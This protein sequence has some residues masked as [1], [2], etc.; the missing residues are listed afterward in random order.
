MSANRPKTDGSKRKAPKTAFR[1]GQS[2]NPTGRPPLTDEQRTAREMLA[3]GGPAA[4]KYL[5]AVVTGV[6]EADTKERIAAAKVFVDK[7]EPVKLEMKL[8]TTDD[9][10]LIEVMKKMAGVTEKPQD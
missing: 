7:L 8:D 10:G 4:V 1:P 6:E 5:L 2:G 9:T 3:A